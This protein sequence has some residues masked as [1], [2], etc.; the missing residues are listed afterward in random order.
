MP[1]VVT[2]IGASE[3]KSRY[4][5]MAMTALWEHGHEVKLV[6]PFKANIDGHRCFKT[7]TDI[8]EKVDTVTLYVNPARFR[9]H[10]DE[11]IRVRPERVIFNPG[12]EDTEM[13]QKLENAGIR[14]IRA[15]TLVLLSNG[16]F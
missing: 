3:K 9:D 13:E 1:E 12:T 7:I 6:N 4:A 8:T 11:V 14:A 16:Q 5:H 15:C 10:I 2:I